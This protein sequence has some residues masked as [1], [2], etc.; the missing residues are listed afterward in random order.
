MTELEVLTIY[1]NTDREK[2]SDYYK[3][4]LKRYNEKVGF[5]L[6]CDSSAVKDGK[7]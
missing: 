4:K 7:K 2:E 6:N 3:K 1:V 5:Y